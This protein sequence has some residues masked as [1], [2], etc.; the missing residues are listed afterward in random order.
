MAP[1]QGRVFTPGD[2]AD[3]PKVAVVNEEFQRRYFPDGALGRQVR[4]FSGSSTE[5]HTIVGVVQ[6]IPDIDLGESMLQ[7]VYFPLSQ[8]P[9]ATMNV[10][11]RTAGDP[12]ALSGRVRQA[13]SEMDRNLPIYN[14]NTIQKTIDDNTWGWRIF[15][16]LFSVFGVAALF[17]ATVG[18]Y[19]VMAFSVS[20]RT[21][22]IGVRMAVGA[23]AADVLRM[24]LRQGAW[25]V[26]LGIVAG[27]GVAVAL[28]NA[29]RLLFFQVSPFDSLTFV[30]VGVLL[31]AHRPG[32]GLRAGTE[33]GAGGSDGRASRAVTTARANRGWREGPG[34]G[35]REQGTG[36]RDDREQGTQ[37]REQG[38]RSLWAV[39][40]PRCAE[41]A[42]R[43]KRLPRSPV[44]VPRPR[45]ASIWADEE[46]P[47]GLSHRPGPA[48]DRRRGRGLFPLP[49][50]A[51]GL[52]QRPADGRWGSAAGRGG[53]YRSEAGQHLRLRRAG[54]RRAH[55][56]PGAAL[57][58]RPGPREG[59]ARC[60]CGGVH[61]E[62]QRTGDDASRRHRGRP[63][64][65]PAA[66]RARAT[67]RRCISTPAAPR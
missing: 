64:A 3:A 28:S 2:G 67:C 17:L 44:P 24:V 25:Q 6:S 38:S 52:R 48:D 7:H 63:V 16:T 1:R 14:V 45:C 9:N 12:L 10:L 32:R 55:G 42:E 5:W 54:E 34:T 29:M 47:R 8:R 39:A 46:A 65:V 33:S 40:L 60:A 36:N 4:T 11:L 41:H 15:G 19:G 58:A 62:V 37:N 56:R 20:R 50:G 18:L 22:E 49:G 61:R 57:P 66:R 59:H 13:V 27:L 31:L 53:R 51:A 43:D 26:G 23:G 35:N 30:A 21:Q